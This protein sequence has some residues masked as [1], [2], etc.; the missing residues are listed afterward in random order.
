[1]QAVY[2]DSEEEATANL[3]DKRGRWGAG[4]QLVV[5]PSPYREFTRPLL[6]HIGRLARENSDTIITVVLPEFIPANGG[7]TSFTIKARYS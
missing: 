5:L 7:N 1:M 3:K 6:R 4:A 2:V